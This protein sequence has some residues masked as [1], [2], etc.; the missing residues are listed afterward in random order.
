MLPKRAGGRIVRDINE[1]G[2]D[3]ARRKMKTKAFL[4]SRDQGK[5]AG[6]PDRVLTAHG[7]GIT[8]PSA[9]G[10]MLAYFPAGS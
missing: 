9:P 1:A 2:R 10:A 7:V 6:Q 3:I 5:Q 8:P 4:K